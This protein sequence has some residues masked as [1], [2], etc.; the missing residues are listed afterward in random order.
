MYITYTKSHNDN[1]LF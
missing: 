1:H